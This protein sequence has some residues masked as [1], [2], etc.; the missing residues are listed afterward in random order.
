MKRYLFYIVHPSKYHVFKNTINHLKSKGH[1][2]DILI[3]SKDVLEDLIK[4]EGWAH[5]NIFP[6]GRKM[7]G[8]HPY[9]SAFINTFLTIIKIEYFLFFKKR[10]HLF[11]TDDLLVVNGRFRNVA[12]ILLQDDDVVA[13]PESAILHFFTNHILSPSVSD[14]KKYNH[15]IHSRFRW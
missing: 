9:L 13:V 15:K 6:Q 12:S 1:T 3:N 11:I 4:N 8:V 10:Y 2:V 7:K 5:K 14:M